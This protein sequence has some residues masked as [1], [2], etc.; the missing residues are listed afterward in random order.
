VSESE[1]D[2][3][4]R[5]EEAS[6]RLATKKAELDQ[7]AAGLVEASVGFMD[8]WI[9]TSVRQVISDENAV[10]EAHCQLGV[11]KQELAT[12]RKELPDRVRASLQ[13][14]SRAL[15]WNP[16]RDAAAYSSAGSFDDDFRDALAE[17]VGPA[18]EILRRHGYLRRK[19]YEGAGPQ[20]LHARL[21]CYL[22]LSREI[23]DLM[24]SYGSKVTEA[25]MAQE[26][27]RH[28]NEAKRR[29]LASKKWDDA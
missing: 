24:R 18:F 17:A 14:G 6:D 8:S 23:A 5:I 20:R 11:L 19:R 26:G 21:P 12:F 7:L 2:Y 3:S 28:A 16:G 4:A 13:R 27:V 9:E 29:F 15:W 1:A 10:T 25:A 22:Q